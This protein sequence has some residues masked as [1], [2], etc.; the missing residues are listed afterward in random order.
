MPGPIHHQ[1]Q[2]DNKNSQLLK[3]LQP[4]PPPYWKTLLIF[5][6]FTAGSV[7]LCWVRLVKS[8]AL[9]DIVSSCS[10][11]FYRSGSR[12]LDRFLCANVTFYRAALSPSNPPFFAGDVSS[13]AACALI[14][15]IESL[16]SNTPESMKYPMV[17]GLA[18][19][20][21][22]RGAIYPLFWSSFLSSGAARSLPSESIGTFIHQYDA[23]GA[24][25]AT[26]L[27]FVIPGLGMSITKSAHWTL[28]WFV[29]PITLSLIS[30]GYPVIRRL[31]T[32]YHTNHEV[33]QRRAYYFLQASYLLQFLYATGLHIKVLFPRLLHRDQLKALMGLT[34]SIPSIKTTPLS[35]I[36]YEVI[37]F[38]GLVLFASSIVATFGFAR[39][40]TEA[41]KIA[42]WD[43]LAIAACGTGGAL[44]GIWAWRERRLR[45]E[46]LVYHEVMRGI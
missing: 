4:K 18:A 31:M 38:D 19:Q 40:K 8:G 2:R 21:F 16:R 28:A 11:A 23:E 42:L 33:S 27:G 36:A 22:G 14:P 15:L 5:G 6:P 10:T 37:Q 44:A 46:R 34:F 17:T 9:K 39:T 43:L 41:L 25:L 26:L 7:Y 12:L 3:H 30:K 32:P 35:K 24:L 1:E 20:T 29:Y 45:E 13:I